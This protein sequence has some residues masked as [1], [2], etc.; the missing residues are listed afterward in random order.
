VTDRELHAL[1]DEQLVALG[2]LT[3]RNMDLLLMALNKCRQ[4]SA[5]I[6]AEL[7]RRQQARAAVPGQVQAA[8][9][10]LMEKYG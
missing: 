5:L 4:D 9:R 3:V 2:Q 1:T 10:Q 6:Q 8:I 7:R